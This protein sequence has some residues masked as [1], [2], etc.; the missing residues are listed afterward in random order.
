M[1]LLGFIKKKK[2][3][4]GEIKI[5]QQITKVDNNPRYS[6]NPFVFLFPINSQMN[7]PILCL[8]IFIPFQDD[9][10]GFLASNT[11]ITNYNVI[12]CKT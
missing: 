5:I 6:V 9:S 8:F 4:L 1:E 10:Q 12:K 7:V 11:F 3:E 2:K